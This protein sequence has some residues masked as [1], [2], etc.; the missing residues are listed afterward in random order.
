MR[1]FLAIFRK[2]GINSESKSEMALTRRTTQI[3]DRLSNAASYLQKIIK[4]K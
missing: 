3:D 4:K 2:E 1:R